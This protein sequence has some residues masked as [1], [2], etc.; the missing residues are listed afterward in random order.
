MDSYS[1]YQRLT[2]MA[3]LSLQS[4]VFSVASAATETADGSVPT[5][6][7][8]A[9]RF[10][11]SVD[12]DVATGAYD[13]VGEV[14]PPGDSSLL[15]SPQP[16]FGIGL[17][18][19]GRVEPLR[20]HLRSNYVFRGRSRGGEMPV[21]NEAGALSTV[22]ASGVRLP[23]LANIA[24]I[25]PLLGYGVTLE[26]FTIFKNREKVYR[27]ESE[28]SGW[29]YGSILD[30]GHLKQTY[31]RLFYIK[32]FSHLQEERLTVEFVVSSEG[33]YSA[34]PFPGWIS[35]KAG[36]RFAWLEDGRKERLGYL[37]LTL[38]RGW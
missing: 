2:C 11:L 31:V 14:N 23:S 4:L 6:L 17:G 25:E 19:E 32:S 28:R 20:L 38:A 21:L 8:G 9:P 13:D 27:L 18:I 30:I 24:A 36:M 34:K 37:G 1:R 29:V 12:V 26:R 10:A 5:A 16:Y 33:V 7:S 3:V 22:I 35:L 15:I